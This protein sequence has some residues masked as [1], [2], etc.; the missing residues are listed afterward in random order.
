MDHEGPLPADRKVLGRAC[1]EQACLGGKLSS[2]GMG[3]LVNR[4]GNVS[5]RYT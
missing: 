2:C 1:L 4:L 5:S 3:N